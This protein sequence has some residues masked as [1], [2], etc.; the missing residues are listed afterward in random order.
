MGTDD[1]LDRQKNWCKTD[2]VI[3]VAYY[4]AEREYELFPRYSAAKTMIM[5]NVVQDFYLFLILYIEKEFYAPNLLEKNIGGEFASI[6]LGDGAELRIKNT[7]EKLYEIIHVGARANVEK[8]NET[9]A[10]K[11]AE[12]YDNLRKTA[13]KKQKEHYIRI[14][15]EEQERYECSIDKEAVCKELERKVV[16]KLKEKFLPILSEKMASQ[17]LEIPVLKLETYTSDVNENCIDGFYSH[18][19][20]LFLEGIVRILKQNNVL[21]WKMRDSGVSGDTEYLEYLKENDFKILAGSEAML[22][23]RSYQM[24]KEIREQL[25][26]Y[27]TIYTTG[28]WGAIALKE[29]SVTVCLHNVQVTVESATIEKSSAR[30]DESTNK[31]QYAI[32]NDVPLDFDEEE[33]RE[34]LHNHRKKIAVNAIISIQVHEKPVGTVFEKK[35]FT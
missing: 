30:Y 4:L 5:N 24:S 35:H 33:L 7:F 34:Y 31:Y 23:S 26:K 28:M 29:N 16:E 15:R 17:I 3:Q 22:R 14:A 11:A 20:G 1:G 19:C 21:Q 25:E 18:I 27:E 2:V 13:V 8:Y 12:L 9:I 32:I 6:Y 10:V